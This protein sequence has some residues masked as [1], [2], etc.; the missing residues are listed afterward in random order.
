MSFVFKRRYLFPSILCAVFLV[1]GRSLPGRFVFDDHHFVENNAAIRSL[2]NFPRFFS[3]PSTQSGDAGLNADVYRPLTTFSF[4]LN[5]AVTGPRPGY[6]RAVNLLLHSFAVFLLFRL[7]L[8]LGF[9]PAEALTAAAFFALFPTNVESVVWISGRSSALSAVLILGALLCFVKRVAEDRPAVMVPAGLLTLA[10]L[11][12]RET[13]VVIPAL[14]LA[15]L[16]AARAP[17]KKYLGGLTVWMVLPAAGFL[18]LRYFMLGHMQQAAQP[19]MPLYKLAS[20]PFLLFAQYLRILACPFFMLVTYTDA[21]NSQLAD[22]RLHLPFALAAAALYIW[23]TAILRSRGEKAA[24]WG[25]L[26]GAI[27]LLPV[28][29][30]V[31]LT[32]YAAERLLYLPLAGLAL[33]PAAAARALT[34]KR[35]RFFFAACGI[36]LFMLV[37]NIQGRM[38]VWGS[39]VSLWQYDTQKNP[40]NF[41]SRLRLADA[42]R[43]A[44]DLPASYEAFEKA[45]AEA[46]DGRQRAIVFNELGTLQAVSGG[47]AQAGPLFQKAVDLDPGNYLALYNL[48]RL[49]AIRGE[50]EKARSL[51]ERSLR[52]NAGYPPALALDKALKERGK[53]R[54]GRS[55]KRKDR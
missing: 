5:Y 4:A 34:E 54:K 46:A 43:T 14:A 13:A 10:A 8:L 7:C 12:T 36:V 45:L 30:I 15:Y 50:P 44:G 16:I 6:F 48:A 33:L 40:R 35:R 53:E 11:F 39:D 9:G 47:L 19:D 22:L 18:V 26:W 17:F 20:V 31:S 28:L 21:V 32:V 23:L 51:V 3:D 38:K 25:L 27:A 49:N 37:M 52:L 2:S 1:Y 42:L 29:N 55:D 41:L 24:A